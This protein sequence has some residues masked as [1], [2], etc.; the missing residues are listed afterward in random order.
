MIKI[1]N[2]VL[3]IFISFFFAECNKTEVVT[4]TEYNVKLSNPTSTQGTCNCGEDPCKFYNV[5]SFCPCAKKI[6]DNNNSRNFTVN[7]NEGCCNGFSNS[8]GKVCYTGDKNELYVQI[9]NIPVCLQECFGDVYCFRATII[10][11]TKNTFYI[12]WNDA[13]GNY[14]E[15]T[16]D[17]IY[18][19]LK[20]I[21]N[22]ISYECKGSVTWQ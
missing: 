20:C 12:G 4:H 5:L 13:N 1:N 18:I 8:F 16:N 2:I 21:K 7:W 14:L 15:L 11:C 9:S 17:D 19:H 3:F 6:L 22:G 10:K